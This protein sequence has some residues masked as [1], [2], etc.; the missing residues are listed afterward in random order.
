MGYKIVNVANNNVEVNMHV[1]H[2]KGGRRE[3]GNK[4]VEAAWSV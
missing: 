4:K 3:A 1:S 2:R